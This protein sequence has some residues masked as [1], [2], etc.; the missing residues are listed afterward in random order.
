VFILF[1]C[2]S[3][4]QSSP[5]SAL[6]VDKRLVVTVIINCLQWLIDHP[7][8]L[9]NEIYIGGDSYSG[10]PIPVIVQEISQGKKV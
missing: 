6:F 5:F 1:F 8:F 3:I 7:T 4:S 10:I 2:F 9:S